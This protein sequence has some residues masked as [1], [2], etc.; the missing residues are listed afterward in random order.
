MNKD[1]NEY[2]VIIIG[3]GLAGLT[4][5][6]LLAQL[7]NRVL[8]LEQHYYIGGCA[9]TFKRSNFIFDT[10]IHLIGGAEPGG[11][12]H[13]LYKK[14][15]LLD[16]IEFTK[17]DPMVTVQA[18]GLSFP[19]P[20]ELDVLSSR[21]VEWFPE[22]EAAIKKVVNEI[23]YLGGLK[24][25]YDIEDLKIILLLE[26]TSFKEY[27]DVNFKHPHI[28]LLFSSL[29][30]F[31]G[32]PI[33][34][35]STF[36][37]IN[38]MASYNGGAFYPKGN[39]QQLSTVLKDY[40]LTNGGSVVVNRRV[41]R[42]LLKDSKI[43]GVIDQRGNFYS[44]NIVISNADIKTTFTKMMDEQVLP[45]A[46]KRRLERGKNSYSAVLLYGV[47]KNEDWTDY[48]FSHETLF[49]SDKSVENER[50]FCFDPLAHSNEPVISFCCPSISEPSLA[51]DGYSIVNAMAVCDS[52]YME[53]IR[54]ERGKEFI[55]ENF[56]NLLDT[57]VPGIKDNLIFYEFATPRTIKR[58][59]LNDSGSIYGWMKSINRL[60]T[61][62]FGPET[63][64]EGLYLAGHW[65]GAH[66]VYGVVRTGRLAAEKIIEKYGI[67]TRQGVHV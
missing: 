25:N 54:S 31:A 33:D 9:H 28:K 58:F 44:S 14:L 51:P 63:P 59:T 34:K 13:N 23:K 1:N 48:S 37:M 60:G 64:I 20:A 18:D 56:L 11:E 49:F 4:S 24:G 50:D 43:E 52:E 65:A 21:L 42:I 32:V 19:V 16:K 30:L 27:L 38:I 6:A 35:L 41:E 10:A 3:S 17:I 39:S 62:S 57:K 12:I 46:F 15:K 55:A 29:I 53:Q 5:A 36:K 47:I 40:I 7:G 66:G 67:P 45:K 61:D 2:D 8:V 22:E 26:K